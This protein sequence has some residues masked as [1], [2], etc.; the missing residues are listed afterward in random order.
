MR[1]R[2]A[3]QHDAL[4]RISSDRAWLALEQIA[5]VEMTSEDPNFPIEGALGATGGLGWRAAQEG[6]QQIRIIFDEPVPLHRIQVR[7][8]EAHSERT[9]EFTLRWSPAA[10]GPPIE[11]VRQQWNFSPD[12]STLELED[13]VVDLDAVAVLELA[14]QPD[15]SR[16][17]A[18]ATLASLRLS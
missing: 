4:P 1:K 8:H 15:V 11:I 6:A 16:R 13:Y 10:G 2:I 7:F 3:G 18:L 14:I 5:T 17:D 12:G 9:Q